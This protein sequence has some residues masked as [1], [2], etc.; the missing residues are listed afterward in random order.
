MTPH[1]RRARVAVVGRFA[2][3]TQAVE[4]ALAPVC[5]PFAVPAQDSLSTDELLT[6]TRRRRA[7]LVLLDADLG[8]YVDCELLVEQLAARGATVV[9]LVPGH[10][11]RLA[12]QLLHRGA[13]AAV[14]RD[15]G[16][17]EVRRVV[18][19]V[20]DRA[21]ATAPE[22]PRR[23]HAVQAVG[24]TQ[25]PDPRRTAR[26]L[27]GR[28]SRRE[29]AILG[30]LMQGR[31]PLEIARVHVVSEQTVRSQV[32]SILRKLEVTS[33]LAA[34]AAAWQAGWRPPLTDRAA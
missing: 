31:G 21:P 18:E 12:E 23:L 3:V 14:A 8:G 9:V 27:L 29:A 2:L 28:L 6:A 20:A 32:K 30:Q 34:V 22:E 33:Q 15:R 17:A 24:G 19:Q 11:V 1:N 5:R 10:D 25:S 13:I 7:D 16:L 26:R 4:L